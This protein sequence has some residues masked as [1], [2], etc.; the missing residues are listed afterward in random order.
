M[1]YN[2][3]IEDPRTPA[4]KAKDYQWEEIASGDTPEIKWEEREP[5]KFP[6]FDQ[7]GSSSCVSQATAKILGIDEVVEKREFIR[8][9]ARDIYTR[10]VNNSEGMYLPN[11]LQI[12]TEHGATTEELVPSEKRNEA[13]M[14]SKENID[15]YTDKIAEK[16]K[17]KGYIELP[18]DMEIIAGVLQQGKAVLFGFRFDMDEWTDFPNVNPNSQR[19]I[20]HGVAGVDFVLKDGKK[21]IVI[22]DSW[23]LA[24]AKQGQRYISEDFLKNRCFY[25][26]TTINLITETT[27]TKPKYT[28]S[29]YMKKGDKNDDVKAL[30]DI[31][32]YEGFFPTNIESTGLYGSI[33]QK[34]VK[35]FQQKYLGLNNGGLQCGPKTLEALN[36]NYS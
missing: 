5:R 11:A 21:Y 31:L 17:A 12:A 26:G 10:R 13:Q 32:K 23:G 14:N 18:K 33:T 34:G 35:Q 36:I 24:Y 15:P 29:K 3:I 4:E 27:S 7:D 1:E 22:D 30:Q 20:G 16:Y 9:S 28:F 6:I 2:G 8:L 25:V 19:K